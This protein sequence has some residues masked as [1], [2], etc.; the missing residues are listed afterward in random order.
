ML[1]RLNIHLLK[2]HKWLGKR[3]MRKKILIMTSGQIKWMM[4]NG[5]MQ[6]K[7]IKWV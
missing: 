5:L 1:K 2:I 3:T 6:M 4:K 7:K